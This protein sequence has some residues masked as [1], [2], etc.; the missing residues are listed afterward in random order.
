MNRAGRCLVALLLAIGCAPI[1]GCIWAR[2]WFGPRDPFGAQAPCALRPDAG[3][4]EVVAYINQNTARMPAWRANHAT[5]SARGAPMK[6]SAQVAVAAPRKF[7]LTARAFAPEVDLGSNDEQFWF[8]SKQSPSN[9]VYVASHDGESASSQALPVPF[10][11]DWIM[12]SL[13]VIPIDPTSVTMQPGAPGTGTLH[14]LA[15]TRSP[16]GRAVRKVTVV[17]Q[18]HGVVREQWLY[19]EQ[20]QPI[21]WARMYKHRRVGPTQAVLPERID[22][23]WPQAQLSLSMY[24][25]P[26]EVNPPRMPATLWKVPDSEHY[27]VVPAGR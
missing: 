5:I 24:L 9:D 23:E 4:G 17:D 18:C 2:Q 8:W 20:N 1:S 11:P 10:Q 15:D 7:R 3:V 26:V 16:E 22:L 12:E 19:D 25:G 6:L 14:L 21:A 13:G 27:G